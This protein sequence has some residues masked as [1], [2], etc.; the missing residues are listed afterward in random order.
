MSHAYEETIS[1]HLPPGGIALVIIWEW[2]QS[3][4]DG[5]DGFMARRDAM[6]RS[7]Y[8]LMR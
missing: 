7:G 6:E 4:L 5:L 8:K 3:H 1:R 2:N